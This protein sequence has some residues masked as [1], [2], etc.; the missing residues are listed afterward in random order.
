M[1]YTDKAYKKA[2]YLISCWGL[3]FY[4]HDK[5]IASY[6]LTDF[7]VT[8]DAFMDKKSDLLIDLVTSGLFLYDIANKKHKDRQ[9]LNIDPRGKYSD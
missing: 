3:F 4:K 2:Q 1:F 9:W 5:Y 7:K 6:V 8:P